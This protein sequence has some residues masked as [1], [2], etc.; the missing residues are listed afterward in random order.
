[1][2]WKTRNKRYNTSCYTSKTALIIKLQ[3]PETIKALPVLV[4][5]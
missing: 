2:L 5:I 4:V 3:C 1:M